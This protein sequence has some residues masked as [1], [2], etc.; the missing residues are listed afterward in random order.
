MKL[1]QLLCDVLDTEVDFEINGLAIDSRL[2]QAGNA[3]I[4]LQGSSQH[5]MAHVDEAIANGACVVLYEPAGLIMTNLDELLIPHFPV[6]DLAQHLGKIA[7]RFYDLPARKLA[8][9]GVTGTNGKTTCSQ[10]IAQALDDCGVIGTLG[11]GVPGELSPTLNTT[12]D[13][14]S[15]QHMLAQFVSQ[16]KAV[17]AMEVSSHGLQLGR[18]NS[19][20]FTGAV[21]TNLSRDHLDFHGSMEGYFQAK[22]SLFKSSNLKFAVLNADDQAV[23]TVR[24]HL[25]ANVKCWTFSTKG[26]FVE[27][28]ESIVAKH[29]VMSAD[30]I[31][32]QV[33]W[34]EQIADAFTPLVGDFNLENV[35]AVFA[36]MLAMGTSFSVA[37]ANLGKLKATLG[38]MEKFGGNHKPT[39]FVDYAHTP[40]ALEKVLK[41]LKG[42]G[43]LWVVFGCGGN[44]DTGKRREMGHIAE[45]LADQ[46]IITDDNPRDEIASEI[47]NEILMGCQSQKVKVIQNR[48]LAIDT[49]IQQATK[50]DC[51]VIAGKGHEEYQ[52]ING[53]KFPFS[54][55]AA[56]QHSLASWNH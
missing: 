5:G 26:R 18:I 52:E 47:I 45:T 2:V 17:V 33:I 9:I 54:D 22:L 6:P 23:L 21:F 14:L 3:F 4:A 32:F 15:I 1:K 46:V 10:L 12:P 53:V 40:D 38:R 30:G 25:A 42:L 19:V 8:I 50:N 31:R 34:G 28:A 35:L 36:V 7:A 44:R 41:G 16:G 20:N 49:A 27:G 48:K 55:Q 43:Q 11:W 51:I 13:A 56:V 24:N 37:V 29:I 39:V